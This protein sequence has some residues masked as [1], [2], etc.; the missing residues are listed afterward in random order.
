MSAPIV[1]S[2]T[3]DVTLLPFTLSISNP[4]LAAASVGMWAAKAGISPLFELAREAGEA[5]E[6]QPIGKV[7]RP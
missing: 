3:A 4:L 1:V 7:D 2:A 5:Q 6:A